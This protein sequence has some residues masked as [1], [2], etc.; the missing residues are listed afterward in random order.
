MSYYDNGCSSYIKTE[1]T[2]VNYFPVD[3]RGTADIACVF[4]RYFRDGSRRCSLTNEVIPYPNKY[5]GR[6]CPLTPVENKEEK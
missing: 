4:C 1:A 5:V 3:S 2:V 6:E